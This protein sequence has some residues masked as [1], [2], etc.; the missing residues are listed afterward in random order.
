MHFYRKNGAVFA[1]ES[2]G[3]QDHLITPDMV[4]MSQDEVRKVTGPT[5]DEVWAAIKAER[6]RRYEAGCLVAG[7]WW[8]S[9]IKSRVKWERKLSRAAAMA[10]DEPYAIGGRVEAWKTMDGTFV[11]LTA[12]LIR[13][14]A[15]AFEIHDAQIFAAA[16]AHRAA[17]EASHDPAHYDYRTGWPLVYVEAS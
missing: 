8:H 1:F 12:G 16:E 9:D 14:V 5:T 17:M 7:K 3:S 13:R 10:D 11:D 2:D 15:D 4:P 6:D